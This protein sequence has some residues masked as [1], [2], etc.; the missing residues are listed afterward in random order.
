MG[1]T[2]NILDSIAPSA[3]RGHLS[4]REIEDGVEVSAIALCWHLAAKG[5][6][7][8]GD[9][10][11]E[12]LMRETFGL[13]VAIEAAGITLKKG[14]TVREALNEMA[15][16]E[17]SNR[18]HQTA[19]P[20]TPGK[21]TATMTIQRQ[22]NPADQTDSQARR[23][24]PLVM[25]AFMSKRHCEL[26]AHLLRSI[27]A[28][29]EP[30]HMSKISDAE[31]EERARACHLALCWFLVALDN[32]ARRDEIATQWLK[33]APKLVCLTVAVGVADNEGITVPEAIKGLRGKAKM[34][35]IQ[36]QG[37][38]CAWWLDAN[39]KTRMSGPK[40]VQD[41]MDQLI[42]AH[43]FLGAVSHAIGANVNALDRD[44]LD[45]VLSQH[46]TELAQL[47]ADDSEFDVSPEEYEM[48]VE[49]YS[50]LADRELT[51]M[52][53]VGG[54]SPAVSPN[55]MESSKARLSCSFIIRD[56]LMKAKM[57][58]RERRRIRL[59]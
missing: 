59:Q 24:P 42:R 29:T 38:T 19:E 56:H 12:G 5:A 14:I 9:R 7:A 4:D 31:L 45:A 8:T 35:E 28:G 21:T 43:D 49:K 27:D 26:A 16:S 33:E 41:E 46:H 57:E 15:E 30:G 53:T 18:Q 51:H 37:R 6:R 48:F 13:M 11:G 25:P 58:E 55:E 2:E 52:I 47:V 50:A 34:Y 39:G 22:E 20:E 32:P 17:T 54:N 36:V 1:L 44:S 40:E 3:Q 10:Y 23:L